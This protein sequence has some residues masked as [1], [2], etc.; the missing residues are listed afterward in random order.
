MV[1]AEHDKNHKLFPTIP[2]VYV[3]NLDEIYD[4]IQKPLSYHESIWQKQKDWAINNWV[5]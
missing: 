4:F 2:D 3:K 5:L 1:Y